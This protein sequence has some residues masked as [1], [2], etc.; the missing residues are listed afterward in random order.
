MRPL[1]RLIV[2]CSWPANCHPLDIATTQISISS[3]L[4]FSEILVVSLSYKT[5]RTRFQQETWSLS[6]DLTLVGPIE[7]HTY[8]GPQIH[9]CAPPQTRLGDSLRAP[10][11]FS[12]FLGRILS[13]YFN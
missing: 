1:F 6:L 10:K 4:I 2:T 9:L 3:K 8:L 12:S 7:I 13:D 11:P 5:H